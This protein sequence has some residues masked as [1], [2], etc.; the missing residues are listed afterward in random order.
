M[1]AAS[2]AVG[3]V[4]AGLM[5]APAGQASAAIDSDV[6]TWGSNSFGQLGDGSPLS[7]MRGT[8]GLV[9]VSGVIEISGGREHVI[10]LKDDGTVVTWGSDANGALGNG[11]TTGNQ[12]SPV[13]VTGLSGVIDVDDGHYHSLALKGDGTVWGWGQNHLGQLAQGNEA[14]PVTS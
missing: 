2:A 1:V 3:V 13:N 10:A 8:P 6:Y 7:T 14:S 5:L 11:A 9:S 4:A 12:P